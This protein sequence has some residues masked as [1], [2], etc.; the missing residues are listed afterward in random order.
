MQYHIQLQSFLHLIP[1]A[2]NDMHFSIIVSTPPPK[3]F[4][5][6]SCNQ[7]DLIAL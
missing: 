2:K 6:T 5:L 3:Q 1:A 7:S 4:V